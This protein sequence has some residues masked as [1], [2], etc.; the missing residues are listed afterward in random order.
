M[1][2]QKIFKKENDKKKAIRLTGY[3]LY[4]FSGKNIIRRI[5]RNFVTLKY[6]D[7]AILILILISTILLTL[8]NPLDDPN[9]QL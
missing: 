4:I 6:F 2:K 8:D 5:L 9:G 7:T 3:S 1:R